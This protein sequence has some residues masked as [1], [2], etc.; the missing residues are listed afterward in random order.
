MNESTDPVQSTAV[1]ANRFPFFGTM[2]F[3]SIN[4]DLFECSL[5][6]LAAKLEQ[7]KWPLAFGRLDNCSPQSLVAG[8]R[9][10]KFDCGGKVRFEVLI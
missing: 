9:I 6:K 5:R 3:P 8:E 4:F 10:W 7:W 2:G 1:L